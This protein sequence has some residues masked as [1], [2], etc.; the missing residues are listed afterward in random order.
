MSVRAAPDD[1]IVASDEVA[2]TLAALTRADRARLAQIARMRCLG[3]VGLEWTDLLNEAFVRMLDGRRRWPRSVPLVAFIA[4]T[5]RS[6]AS[7]SRSDDLLE[8]GAIEAESMSGVEGD[9]PLRALA[10]TDITPEREVA[11]QKAL[12]AIDALF[13]DDATGHAVLGGLA[14]GE[15]A[16]ELG[17]RLQL[18][19]T[20]YAS[21]L[22]RIRRRL[23]NALPNLC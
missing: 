15:T 4:Q 18:D 22:R 10:H 23:L 13:A 9:A 17:A 8:Y 12:E 19:A 21:T 3:V 5:M 1:E 2:A 16:S 6:I 20:Q 14:E 7:E 11:A